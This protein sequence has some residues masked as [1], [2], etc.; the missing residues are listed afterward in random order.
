M[1]DEVWEVAQDLSH[2]IGQ[3]CM[4]EERR[5]RIFL[6]APKYL[7]VSTNVAKEFPHLL[8]SIIV[9]TYEAHLPGRR[10]SVSV[11]LFLCSDILVAIVS[12]NAC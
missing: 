4:L 5:E 12:W 8:E 2:T 1:K 10:L 11:S 6:D 9:R 3:L 7:F